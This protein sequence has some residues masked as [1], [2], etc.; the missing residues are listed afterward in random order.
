MQKLKFTLNKLKKSGLKYNI[1]RYFFGKTEMEYL[2]FWVTRDGV[3][4][5]DKNRSNKNMTPPTSQK[6]FYKVIGLV[7]YYRYMWT[8]CLHTLSSLT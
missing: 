6:E 7:N 4:N 1:E 5:I 8:R 3:K 2:G